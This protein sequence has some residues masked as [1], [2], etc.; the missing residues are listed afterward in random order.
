MPPLLEN[1]ALL[2]AYCDQTTSTT[3][4]LMKAFIPLLLYCAVSLT[5]VGLIEARKNGIVYYARGWYGGNPFSYSTGPGGSLWPSPS[6]TAPLAPAYADDLENLS[7]STLAGDQNVGLIT[8]SGGAVRNSGVGKL[9][10]ASGPSVWSSIYRPGVVSPQSV[11]AGVETTPTGSRATPTGVFSAVKESTLFKNRDRKASSFSNTN[12]LGSTFGSAESPTVVRTGSILH[13][14]RL[15][16]SVSANILKALKNQTGFGQ[17]LVS[18][19]IHSLISATEPSGSLKAHDGATLKLPHGPTLI[20]GVSAPLVGTTSLGA[21]GYI[22]VSDNS[23]LTGTAGTL[24]RH[25]GLDKEPALGAIPTNTKSRLPQLPSMPGSSVHRNKSSDSVVANTVSRS[26]GKPGIHNPPLPLGRTTA[27]MLPLDGGSLSVNKTESAR[28]L[29]VD[30]KRTALHKN[31]HKNLILTENTEK[32]LPLGIL[33]SPAGPV[34]AISPPHR[35]FPGIVNASGL[36]GTVASGQTS[37]KHASESENVHEKN[38]G[39]HSGRNES[40]T[41]SISSKE[42]SNITAGMTESTSGA[43]GT[44]SS[45]ANEQGRHTTLEPA[46][47]KT[48]GIPNDRASG[49]PRG[50][51]GSV[52]VHKSNPSDITFNPVIPPSRG[53]RI[54]FPSASLGGKITPAIT[55]AGDVIPGKLS[56]ARKPISESV[57]SVSMAE[58][59]KNDNENSSFGNEN[60]PNGMN[61]PMSPPP[62][63]SSVSAKPHLGRPGKF[64]F[65]APG[66]GLGQLPRLSA[67]G[68]GEE[69]LPAPTTKRQIKNNRAYG[70]F[71]NTSLPSGFSISST[72]VPTGSGSNI[73]HSP[74]HLGYKTPGTTK[75]ATTNA[76]ST[77]S[78]GFHE[79]ARGFQDSS[80]RT[81]VHRSRHYTSH[82]MGIQ[83]SGLAGGMSGSPTAV[84]PSHPFVRVQTTSSTGIN[85]AVGRLTNVP[86]SNN[87]SRVYQKTGAYGAFSHTSLP[88]GFSISSTGVPTGPGSKVFRASTYIR[89]SPTAENIGGAPILRQSAR[90]NNVREKGFF[91]A[92]NHKTQ[93]QNSYHYGHPAIAIQPPGLAGGISE[94]STSMRASHPF[95]H[96]QAFPNTRNAG[97]VGILSKVPTLSDTHQSPQKTE[98]YG[99]FVHGSLPSGFSI[100]STGVPTG[101]GSQLFRASTHIRRF[102]SA[103]IIGAAATSGHP[104]RPGEI[105]E[106]EGFPATSP[107]TQ[108]NNRYQYAP[109]AHRRQYLGLGEDIL[110]SSASPKHFH[111]IVPIQAAPGSGSARAGDMLTRVLDFRNPSLRSQKTGAFGSFVHTSLPPGFSISSIRTPNA[112]ALSTFHASEHLEGSPTSLIRR[113]SGTPGTPSHAGEEHKHAG[114]FAASIPKTQ[115]Q[116]SGQTP[117]HVLGMQNI[118]LAGGI[119]KSYAPF[120]NFQP[121]T[122][123]PI[124]RTNGN[125][126][127]PDLL[128]KVPDANKPLPSPPEIEGHGS[129]RTNLPYGAPIGT[130][131]NV[132]HATERLGGPAAFGFSGDTGTPGQPSFPQEVHVHTRGFSASNRRTQFENSGLYR[133]Q[134]LG[135]QIPGY[136]GATLESSAASKV[137]HPSVNIQTSSSGNAGPVSPLTKVSGFV[138]LPQ[139]ARR[140]GLVGSFIP[141]T[142]PSGFRIRSTGAPARAGSGIYRSG[143]RLGVSYGPGIVAASV[144]PSKPPHVSVVSDMKALR[145]SSA[146]TN[147]ENHG[148]YLPPTEGRQAPGL[149]GGVSRSSLPLQTSHPFRQMQPS[150]NTETAGSVRLLGNVPG[151]NNQPQSSQSSGIYDSFIYSRPPPGF[152]ISNSRTPVGVR[153]RIFRSTER[154][155]GSRTRGIIKARGTVRWPLHRSEVHQD[156]GAIL[157]SNT[158]QPENIHQFPSQGLEKQT[159]GFTAG[160]SDSSANLNGNPNTGNAGVVGPFT[161]VN[162]AN[163]ASQHTESSVGGQPSSSTGGYNILPGRAGPTNFGSIRLAND[164]GHRG[165]RTPGDIRRFVNTEIPQ[166]TQILPP[167]PTLAG[168]RNPGGH[169]RTSSDRRQPQR[170]Q[171]GSLATYG[172]DYPGVFDSRFTNGIPNLPTVAVPKIIY[173]SKPVGSLTG[174]PFTITRVVNERPTHPNYV[175]AFN[176]GFNAER[177]KLEPEVTS[178]YKYLRRTITSSSKTRRA[179]SYEPGRPLDL[180]HFEIGSHHLKWLRNQRGVPVR[181]GF[182]DNG[183]KASSGESN[184]GQA[185]TTRSP[186][187]NGVANAGSIIGQGDTIY[188][189]DYTSPSEVVGARRRFLDVRRF[190]QATKP[191]GRFFPAGGVAYPGTSSGNSLLVPETLPSSF[192]TGSTTPA[193]EAGFRNYNPKRNFRDIAGYESNRAMNDLRRLSASATAPEYD[194]RYLTVSRRQPTLTNEYRVIPYSRHSRNSIPYTSSPSD[195][196]ARLSDA[197]NGLNDNTGFR[198][199]E[200]GGGWKASLSGA[201]RSSIGFALGSTRHILPGTGAYSSGTVGRGRSVFIG[202]REGSPN[203]DTPMSSILDGRLRR[204]MSV[205]P[206]KYRSTEGSYPYFPKENSGSSFSNIGGFVVGH[207]GG[208]GNTDHARIPVSAGYR[209]IAASPRPNTGYTTNNP[210]YP[211]DGSHGYLSRSNSPRHFSDYSGIRARSGHKRYQPFFR[212]HS[213]S[214]SSVSS[215]YN[216]AGDP[217]GAW[218]GI[219]TYPVSAS[220]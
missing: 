183:W 201:P 209:D 8:D 152:S 97:A 24:S 50:F 144:A 211:S 136:G 90:P 125:A 199:T 132:F 71:M 18:S 103:G 140:I 81:P 214:D 128:A 208:R 74:Q 64:Q 21:P 13:E 184:G 99:S 53:S 84:V 78:N 117:P 88:S 217:R 69:G 156:L 148:T 85:G 29:L 65:T 157:T 10:V 181:E 1:F 126:G 63:A 134:A 38:F 40:H 20:G 27:A 33:E 12:P 115:V 77:H 118:L 195:K 200:A 44:I 51:S 146:G 48:R 196:P 143:E 49:S 135:Q 162:G 17:E 215:Q 122:N 188:K 163:K 193:H 171:F 11:N 205:Y 212:T 52:L 102:P 59:P 67:A 198:S 176:G 75:V 26:A 32:A 114:R 218:Q 68:K 62:S 170:A 206:R 92:S 28:N 139:H 101:P 30:K 127:A 219:G 192:N 174:S 202:G 80:R 178:P 119:S 179:D 105:R 87:P 111:P 167:P 106:H 203:T 161:E 36:V 72:G 194:T 14:K 141:T 116:Y 70:L 95:M 110:E 86:S 6:A 93:P 57:S 173:T 45:V 154:L 123:V 9:D 159:Y 153:S 91:P 94:S 172:S 16:S 66:S 169:F 2:R 34:P 55:K 22:G 182:T 39:I 180:R 60:L 43:V 197:S 191:T 89:G 145:S 47:E 149:A 133:A 112:A 186:P 147:F 151:L 46:L 190:G 73:F 61:T 220:N 37:S 15:G 185:T 168:T 165:F 175:S 158:R 189:P 160:I 100:S 124:S 82:V 113:P 213:A 155:Q 108:M 35:H 187:A 109:N 204:S 25:N 7:V 83:H 137:P 41:L 42:A 58:N 207:D 76:E 138:S 142:L 54:S 150:L 121:A 3:Q 79:H 120:E 5:N 166:S 4:Q 56:L 23:G 19:K 131:S 177:R 210:L 164:V 98:A 129:D 96:V 130:A 31:D 216:I 104:P 107:K